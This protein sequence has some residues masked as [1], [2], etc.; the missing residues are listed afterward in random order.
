MNAIYGIFQSAPVPAALGIVLAVLALGYNGAR[1]ILWTLLGAIA[2]VGFGAPVPVLIGFGAIALIFNTPARRALSGVIMKVMK[3]FMPKIS[4]T[5]RTA[6]DAGVTWIEKDLFSGKPDFNSILTEPYPDLTAEEKAFV[7]GPVN[8][9][10]QVVDDWAVWRDRELPKAAW[11]IIK[12]EKF[13]GMIIPKEYGGLGFSALCHSEVIQRL[14]TRSIP[15]TITVMVPNSLGPAELLIHYGTE[16]QKRNLLPKLAS[17]EEIPC[18]AL[19]EPTAG[20]DA[21]SMKSTG[22]LFKDASGK[23]KIRLNWN[24]RYITLAAISTTLGLAFRLLDPEKLLGKGEDLGITCALIPS[25]TKGV[26]LGRRHDPLGVPFYNCPTQ[27]KDVE[28]DAEECIPGGIKNAGKG[29]EMLMECLAAG[30]GISLP[31]QS[32]GTSKLVTRAVG[33]YG[34]IRKQFGVSIGKFEGIEDPMAQ[35]GGFNY[36]LE[37]MRKFTLGALDKG[38]KPP[39]ITAMAKYN[40]TELSRKSLVHGMDI[41]G[42]AAISRGPR[43]LL[44]HSYIGAPIG[45]TVEGANIM[46]RTLIIFGQGALRA[47]P[48][49]YQEVASVE[50]GDV[51]GFDKAFWGHIGHVVRNTFRAVLLSATRG[52]LFR[53]PVGKGVGRYYQKLAWV[54]ASFAILAD[55]AMGT[56]G[57][58][59]K[60]REK[61]TGRFA[62]ILSWL[63]MGTA[64][65]RRYAAEGYR[66]ED[67]PF[68][69]YSMDYAFARIQEAFDGLYGN[70]GSVMGP[71]FAGPVRAWSHFNSLGKEASDKLTHKLATLIQKDGEQR[72]RMVEGLFFPQGADEGLTRLEHAYKAIIKAMPIEKKIFKAIKAKTIKRNKNIALLLESALKA[73]V[74]SETEV[75]DLK[76][77]EELRY[78]AVLVDDYSQDEYLGRVAGPVAKTA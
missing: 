23:Y 48:Y 77:M 50:K 57:G 22:T 55:I 43:N 2:L 40:A 66:K 31:A 35:I 71:V 59:L 61:V 8:K 14:A 54:S 37:A 74:I 78:D 13:L 34:V 20:S 45:I 67:L 28:I 29:W 75:A 32:T 9:L 60:T 26:V 46:T 42:G 10:C 49:A 76:R 68:V 65:L 53:P 58:S 21:G 16:A 3:D 5:E 73:G 12:K 1:L 36:I 56:L 6:L 52:Y 4:E 51:A 25:N 63:Y 7:E 44:A 27:G 72:D 69:D 41:L 18:F 30:R 47:H 19:T 11:D 62:D 39:V 17:G 38:I 70:I 15:A 33:N 24:K 64:V